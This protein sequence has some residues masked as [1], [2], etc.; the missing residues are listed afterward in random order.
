ME[1]H[2]VLWTINAKQKLIEETVYNLSD[3]TFYATE[4]A[5]ERT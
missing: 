4:A 2:K 1:M 3:M 5:S